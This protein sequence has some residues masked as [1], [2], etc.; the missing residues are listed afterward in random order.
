MN[1]RSDIN[2]GSV[3]PDLCSCRAVEAGDGLA[4]CGTFEASEKKGKHSEKVFIMAAVLHPLYYASLVLRLF[5][6]HKILI[7]LAC[8]LSRLKEVF[9]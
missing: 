2:G 7:S 1:L 6:P 3:S 4:C 9:L 5:L 8:T